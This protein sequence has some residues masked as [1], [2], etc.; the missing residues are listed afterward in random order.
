MHTLKLSLISSGIFKNC[1]L[2]T[3]KDWSFCDQHRVKCVQIRSFFWSVFSRIWTKYREILRFQS[4]CGKIRTRKKLRI[5]TLVTQC[6]FCRLQLFYIKSLKI[7]SSFFST[8]ILFFFFLFFFYQ[9][10]SYCDVPL[11]RGFPRKANIQIATQSVILTFFSQPTH[12]PPLKKSNVE[13]T[14]FINHLVI[15]VTLKMCYFLILKD[16]TYFHAN[17]LVL[18]HLPRNIVIQSQSSFKSKTQQGRWYNGIEKKL[19][20]STSKYKNLR[21]TLT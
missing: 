18:K 20:W 5:W 14:T 21:Y 7:I 8:L 1:I 3:T 10:I 2:M 12:P 16:V 4:E 15:R 17:G 19:V 13:H 9:I 6:K 11:S